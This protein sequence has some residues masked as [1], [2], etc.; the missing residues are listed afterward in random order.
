MLSLYE[1][2]QSELKKTLLKLKK[3]YEST[4]LDQLHELIEECLISKQIALNKRNLNEMI[5]KLQYGLLSMMQENFIPDFLVM[6]ERPVEV[7]EKKF[8][9]APEIAGTS[10]VVRASNKSSGGSVGGGRGASN[11][12]SGQTYAVPSMNVGQPVGQPN[13]V[14]I[15]FGPVT[16]ASGAGQVSMPG[17]PGQSSLLKASPKNSVEVP[18][19][20]EASKSVFAEAGG[21]KLIKVEQ[22][23][24]NLGQTNQTS[25]ADLQLAQ[26]SQPSITIQSKPKVGGHP[27][28]E[29]TQLH[30]QDPTSSPQPPNT[31][32]LGQKLSETAEPHPIHDLSIVTKVSAPKLKLSATKFFRLS[33]STPTCIMNIGESSLMIGYSSGEVGITD[34]ESQEVMKIGNSPVRVIRLIGKHAICGFEGS[35]SNL[36]GFELGTNKPI[37]YSSGHKQTVSDVTVLEESNKFISVGNDGLLCYWEPRNTKPL[38]IMCISNLALV[39]I[40]NLNSGELIVTGGDDSVLRLFSQANGTLV[41]MSEIKDKAP[42]I[43]VESFYQNS[44][45]ILSANIAGEINVWDILQAR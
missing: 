31:N 12:E 2:Q 13:P 38:K 44:K 37:H 34:M 39:S 32:P 29:P 3:Q 17:K 25:T 10:S 5:S 21:S 24:S 6:D 45:F 20:Q 22:T 23:G 16:S 30:Y 19:Y 18:R 27:K 40:T 28:V 8:T 14:S 36:L 41:F 42:I 33:N 7:Q 26:N 35:E 43:K 1:S 9:A 11:Q 4:G 15:S